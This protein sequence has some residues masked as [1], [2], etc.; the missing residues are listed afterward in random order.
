MPETQPSPQAQSE[1]LEQTQVVEGPETVEEPPSNANSLQNNPKPIAENYHL[2][3]F[4]VNGFGGWKDV[5]EL[6]MPYLMV[7]ITISLEGLMKTLKSKAK[8]V[9]CDE[10]WCGRYEHFNSGPRRQN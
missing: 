7:Y 3:A 2:D 4:T 1:V 5:R 6:M 10:P 9:T 8:Y